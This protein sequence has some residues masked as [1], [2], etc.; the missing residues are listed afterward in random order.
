[1]RI[2]YPRITT[3]THHNFPNSVTSD[4]SS[5]NATC[6]SMGPTSNEQTD[7]PVHVAARYCY[8]ISETKYE[9][10]VRQNE[11]LIGIGAHLTNFHPQ[12]RSQL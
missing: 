12:E 5:A 6:G 10:R 9:R 4:T 7:T 2:P 8:P 11:M 1:S 3:G